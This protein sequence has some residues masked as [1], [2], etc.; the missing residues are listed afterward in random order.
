[1]KLIVKCN[2]N[3]DTAG[4]SDVVST[5]VRLA[6]IPGAQGPNAF[7]F[8]NGIGNGLVEFQN[9]SADVKAQFQA[10]KKF[11]MTFEPYEE[12]AQADAS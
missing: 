2:F 12:S 7:A 1:M 5:T 11:V 4:N 8:T 10:G 3:A 9:A 6:A